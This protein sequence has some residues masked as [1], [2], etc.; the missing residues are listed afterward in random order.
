M[1]IQKQRGVGSVEEKE[2]RR[3]MKSRNRTLGLM[4]QIVITYFTQCT[5]YEFQYIM[6]LCMERKVWINQISS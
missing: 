4:F 2:T 5:H 1:K 6:N 3:I